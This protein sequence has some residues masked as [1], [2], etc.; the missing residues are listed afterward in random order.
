M[1]PARS[2]AITVLTT[3]TASSSSSSA[4]QSRLTTPD[5]TTRAERLLAPRQLLRTDITGAQVHRSRRSLTERLRCY[6]A[7]IGLEGMAYSAFTRRWGDLADTARRT[8]FLL[9]A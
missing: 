8:L 4:Q 9:R 6:Q 5:E 7:H 3:D 1:T 2:D